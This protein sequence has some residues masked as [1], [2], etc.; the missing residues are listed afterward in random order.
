MAF[1]Q[2]R[3]EIISHRPSAISMD[4]TFIFKTD[5]FY[6]L[7]PYTMLHIKFLLTKLHFL[8]SFVSRIIHLTVVLGK[9]SSIQRFVYV[10]YI[11]FL[12]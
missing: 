7:R 1:A 10:F 2:K 9:I 8:K 6:L 5:N 12:I 4:I 11:I 3:T